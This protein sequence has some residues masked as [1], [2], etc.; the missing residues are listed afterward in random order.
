MADHRDV[1]I[2]VVDDDTAMREL[3]ELVLRSEGFPVAS[4]AGMADARTRIRDDQADLVIL[5][6]G[7]GSEDG[8]SLLTEIRRD[9]DLPVLLISGDG[10]TDQRVLGLRLGADDFLAKP[11]APIELVARIDS[12]LRRARPPKRPVSHA[13]LR[14]DE[15]AREV[16]LRDRRVGLTAKEFDLLAFLCRSPRQVFSRDQLLERVWQS[17]SEWQDEAT[18]TEHIRRLRQK[19]EDDPAHPRW[20]TT[21]RGV[22]YRF[23]P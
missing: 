9:G 21:V 13:G 15:A 12:V 22:G 4:A 19:I 7:L 23:E 17:R 11:F 8:R 16:H 10:G 14:I 6:V 5:D 3:L 18:V 1:R 2:L 20:I